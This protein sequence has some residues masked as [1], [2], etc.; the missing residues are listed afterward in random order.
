MV[1]CCRMVVTVMLMAVCR[2]VFLGFS[3][4]GQFV[5][6][7]TM[8]VDVNNA[9]SLAGNCYKLQC[10]LFTPYRSLE[11]VLILHCSHHTDD[12]YSITLMSVLVAQI[13]TTTITSI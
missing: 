9:M 6:S 13:S 4:D 2:H 11:L 3:R 8:Q 10:W 12:V 5:F 7:Y 1:C